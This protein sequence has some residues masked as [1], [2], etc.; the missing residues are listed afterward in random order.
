MGEEEVAVL[1]ILVGLDVEIVGLRT[2][3]G[4]HRLRFAVLLRHQSRG[5]EFTKLQ[6]GLHTKQGG[7]TMDERRSR[8]HAHVTGLD[9]LDDLVFL[10]LVSQFQILAVEIKSRSRVIRHVEAHLVT[11]RSGD[12]G[13][14]LLIKI[15][16]GLASLRH[17]QSGV[18]GRIAL[19]THV[20]DHRTGSFQLHSAGAE[21]LLQRSHAKLHL[22]EVKRILLLALCALG[23][24]L[25]VILHHRTPEIHITEFV[26]RHD[27][28]GDDVIVTQTR[29][30]DITASLRVKFHLT[31]DIG[32]CF[33]VGRILAQ[34]LHIVVIARNRWLHVKV[35]IQL[36]CGLLTCARAGIRR[37]RG[38]RQS[39][40]HILCQQRIIADPPTQEGTNDDRN[41]YFFAV[42]HE[43]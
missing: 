27:I 40:S 39:A 4:A 36:R 37:R 11:Y 9:V 8:S 24:L 16:V 19:H 2:A 29:V 33:Q 43:Q 14:N 38:W 17:H 1:I 6:L 26:R 25:T 42:Q 7:A 30:D 12:I 10:A 41:Y 32:R 23:I 3:S 28:G 34:T 31:A 35:K 18:I 20:D 13:L 22:Q 15:K 21:N 5:S